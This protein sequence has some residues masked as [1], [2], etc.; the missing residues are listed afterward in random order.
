MLSVFQDT[1]LQDQFDEK[2]YIIV[3]SLLS[4]ADIETLINLFSEYQTEYT[5]SFHTTHFSS[6]FDYKKKVHTLVS[7]IVFEEAKSLLKGF[8]PVF[9]NFMIKLP[10]P[11]VPMP[12]HADWS[13][14]DESTARSIAIWVPLVD[15]DT[16][17]GCIG[18]VEGSHTITNIIRGPNIK[19]SSSLETD[20]IWA[21]K[22]GKLIPMKAGDAMIYDHRLLHFSPANKSDKVRPALNL[23][24]VP[25]GI[26]VIHFYTP[27]DSDSI[28]K[29]SVPSSD[30]FI[31][32][33]SF[34]RPKSGSISALIPKDSVKYIDSKMKHYR[35]KRLIRSILV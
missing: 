33:D 21:R 32:Y 19:Q 17:N 13:Y 7:E 27:G 28:E 10:D 20:A 14:V 22:Y 30:F 25:E 3:P 6:N 24:L 15:T 11:G 9:G 23:S 29:Y 8:K 31:D 34:Q 26:D 35:L 1:T 16:Q 4:P 12:L 5:S 18:V 2:G